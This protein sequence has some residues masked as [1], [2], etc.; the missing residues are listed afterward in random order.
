MRLASAGHRCSGSN[1]Q[2]L[3]DTCRMK[4]SGWVKSLRGRQFGSILSVLGI[5]VFRD[6]PNE[7]LN[8]DII[9]RF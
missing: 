1:G 6:S 3:Y 4:V 8:I 7:A 9:G 2:A 5:G